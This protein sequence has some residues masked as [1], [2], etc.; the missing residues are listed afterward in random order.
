MLEQQRARDAEAYASGSDL[1]IQDIIRYRR[2]AEA[3][4][5]CDENLF[6]IDWVRILSHG[7]LDSGF[8]PLRAAYRHEMF[9]DPSPRYRRLESRSTASIQARWTTGEVALI[10]GGHQFPYDHAMETVCV[11]LCVKLSHGRSPYRSRKEDIFEEVRYPIHQFQPRDWNFHRCSYFPFEKRVIRLHELFVSIFSFLL[12]RLPVLV[13]S[14][15][16]MTGHC[17]ITL[18][19]TCSMN[20]RKRSQTQ[21]GRLTLFLERVEVAWR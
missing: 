19:G 17:F 20:M 18:T 8:S 16:L 11:E 4:L 9:T 3:L 21:V 5:G 6:R 2:Q 10:P 13:L 1:A 15:I 7:C 14:M 12:H